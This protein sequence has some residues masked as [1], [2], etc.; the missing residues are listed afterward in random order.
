MA[1][2]SVACYFSSRKRSAVEDSKINRAKKVL[3]LDSDEI[4]QRTLEKN[5]IE[6]VDADI[7]TE[8]LPE[9]GCKFKQK[10]EKTVFTKK[11]ITISNAKSQK[12]SKSNTPKSL[13][14][15]NA[16]QISSSGGRN[17]Q[18]LIHN[19][20]NKI[21]TELPQ[22]EIQPH[23]TPPGT[24][25]KI[26]NA[27]DK[28]KEKPDGPSIKEIRKKMSRSARLAELKASISKF[29]EGDNKLKEIEEETKKIP[30]SPK[31][32]S[33]RTIELEVLTR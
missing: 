30:E 6:N 31:L 28:V 8:I 33:F 18:Q 3:V 29:Q 20:K 15:K 22:N 17:I 25:T 1:Q 32:K 16:K 14:S 23:I 13:K 7:K 4:S 27:L 11:V 10:E 5:L 21:E 19:M 9:D 26:T 2:P 12:I 24:P